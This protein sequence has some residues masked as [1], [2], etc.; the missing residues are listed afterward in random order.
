[1]IVVDASVAIKWINKAE[2][3]SEIAY[4]LYEGHIAGIKKIIVP[5]IL[6]LEAANTL[7]TKSNSTEEDI[8][9]GLTFLFD[10]NFDIYNPTLA[11]L[12]DAG[13]LA[14]KYK[15]AVYD[16]LYAVVAKN[17]KC[18]LVTADENFVAKTKFKQVK[19]LNNYKKKRL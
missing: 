18:I 4:S 15:T 8:K 7:A 16:M 9:I 10:A 6:F 19:L 13:V 1:M 5:S 12:V 11:D 14:K 3:E 17:K 2:K